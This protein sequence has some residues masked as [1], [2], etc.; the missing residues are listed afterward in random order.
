ME[1]AKSYTPGYWGVTLPP[2]THGALDAIAAVM[3][4][5]RDPYPP[6]DS[7]GVA[8]FIASRCD[9]EEAAVLTQLADDFTSGGGDT[10]ALEAVE[11]SRPDEF[12]LL[13]FYVYSG[14]YCAPDVLLVVANHSDYHPSPQP[15]GYAIDAEVPIPTIRRGTFVP[16][17]EVRHVLHR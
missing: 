16:T 5:G 13:R 10:G 9:P 1:L 15:L 7:V 2:A 14:Y 17:E 4:P 8:G 3:I 12:V 6:G 11:A